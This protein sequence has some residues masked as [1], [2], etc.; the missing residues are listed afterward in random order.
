MPGRDFDRNADSVAPDSMGTEL[1]RGSE[2]EFIDWIRNRA[3][4]NPRTVPLG[5][6]DDAAVLGRIDS[7]TLVATDMLLEGVHF[8]FPAA[9]PFQAGRKALAV[10]LSDIAAM[11]GQP[12][13][14]FV[15]IALPKSRGAAFGREVMDGIQS[16]ADEFQI[17]I[18][19]GDTNSWDG[20]L[21]ISVTILGAVAGERCVTRSGAVPS[22]RLFVTG[23]LGGSLQGA[24]LDFTPRVHEA[25]KLHSLVNLHAM[26]D[27]SDGLAADLYHILEESRVGCVLDANS[28]PISANAMSRPGIDPL[29]SALSDGED[30]E[31]LFSVSEDDAEL[32]LAKNPLDVRLSCIGHVLPTGDC[33]ICDSTGS[34]RVLPRLGWNHEFKVDG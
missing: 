23:D 14:A 7:E 28:I 2:F 25:L 10:N 9:T 27:V 34:T 29:Q 30:F 24:H 17:V 11:A 18:A 8:A 20:P 19:G 13:A 22:D 33:Q 31:L 6:G 32:L 1:R 26:I 21:I 16:L 5:I 4:G 15:A 3:T 12:V